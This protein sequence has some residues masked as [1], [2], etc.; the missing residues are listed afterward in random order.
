MS[1][2][3]PGTGGAERELVPARR[4]VFAK[5]L[6][7]VNVPVVGV[8]ATGILFERGLPVCGVSGRTSRLI[9]VRLVCVLYLDV[10]V[11]K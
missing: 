1:A 9:E 11:F 10:G 8:A 7:K 5:T 2:S 4:A 3:F 6:G